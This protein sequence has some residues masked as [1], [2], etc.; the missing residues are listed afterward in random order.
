MFARLLRASIAFSRVERLAPDFCEGFFGRG[1][2]CGSGSFR[3]LIK[4]PVD[5]GLV[6]RRFIGIGGKV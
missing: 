2:I 6:T 1:L 5:E 4:L 3:I